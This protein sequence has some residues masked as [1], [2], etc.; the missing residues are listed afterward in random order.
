MSLNSSAQSLASGS[1]AAIAGMIISQADEHSPLENYNI[2][3]YVA[4]G[5]TLISLLILRR[6]KSLS[7]EN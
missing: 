2:V 6:I 1:S 3:G 5:A 7:K 4:I